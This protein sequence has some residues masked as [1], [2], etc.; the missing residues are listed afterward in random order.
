MV[1]GTLILLIL[2]PLGIAA[3]EFDLTV[4]VL[5]G[6]YQCFFQVVTEKHKSFEVDYQVSIN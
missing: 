1:L 5:P 3:G 4:E 2:F 6:K